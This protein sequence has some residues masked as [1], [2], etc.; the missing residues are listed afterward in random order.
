M[1]AAFTL[2]APAGTVH[3]VLHLPETAEPRPGIVVC[4]GFKGFMD[5]GFFP[6]LADL[7]AERGFVVARFNFTGSGI[8]PG[9]DRVSDLD[10]FRANTF[11]RELEETLLVLDALGRELSPDRVDRDRIGLFGHSRGGGIALLAAARAPWRERLGALVTWSAIS[12]FDRYDEETVERWRERGE[13]VV[14]NTRTGQEL[15]LGIELLEDFERRRDELDVTAAAGV[16]SAP[17]LIVHGTEDATV[18]PEEAD[19]L[20]A[21]AAPPYRVERIAGADHVFGARHPFAGPT[22]HLVAAFNAT[23]AWFCRHLRRDPTE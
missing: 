1:S 14:L 11:S 10:A 16:R 7:L 21:A 15:P 2:Q 5:W 23:Q 9:E 19:V 13:H 3:G 17:W 6:P 18:A 22:P 20:E 8:P 4:H 12:T